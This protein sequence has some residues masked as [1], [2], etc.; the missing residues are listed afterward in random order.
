MR[1]I[2]SSRPHGNSTG[3]TDEDI[4]EVAALER[5]LWRTILKD[6]D[7][8][9]LALRFPPLLAVLDRLYGS[10]PEV[11]VTLRPPGFVD[12]ENYFFEL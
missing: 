10:P 3:Y 9:R 2:Y 11:T 5:T 12:S 8:G 4:N 1:A 7:G 6:G